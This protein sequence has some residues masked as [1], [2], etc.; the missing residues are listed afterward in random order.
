[1]NFVYR[2]AFAI[3]C[4]V[5][6]GSAFAG[7]SDPLI[8]ESAIPLGD[9]SGRIDHLAVD[10]VHQRLFVAELGNDSVGVVDLKEGRL[11]KTLAGLREPQ[12]I[13]YVPAANEIYV[14]N[15]GD[16]TVRI[17]GGDDL[18]SR[19]QV[20]L[21]RDADNVRV[22]FE[23][24]RVL[25]GYGSGG[26]AVIDPSSHSRIANIK[27]KGHPEGFQVVPG[28]DRV[29]V[30]VPDENGLAV[31]DLKSASQVAF[32]PLDDV[33]G[34]FPLAVSEMAGDVWLVTRSPARLL[35]M[36]PATGT[37]TTVLD[38]CGDADDVFT[39]PK[40]HRIYVSC[41]SGFIDVWEQKAGAYRRIAH[42]V[43]PP[44]ART[45]LFVPG[46]DKLYLAV[47]ATIGKPAA[48]WVFRLQ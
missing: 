16:G 43:I 18:A 28:T 38:S 3:L 37:R 11:L 17:F 26:L 33:R 15:G 5:L 27:F 7:E 14:A 34:N 9:V 8:L 24:A 22:A 44:G 23:P 46:L 31:L 20:R 4:A 6:A 47:R 19:G 35:A 45:A 2:P 13:G 10:L 1:V 29:I 39:D 40:R 41:G 21:G 42:Q 36:S 30:N 48:I 25:V 32:W 12:G